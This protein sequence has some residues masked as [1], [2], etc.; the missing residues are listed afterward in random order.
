MKKY[1]LL[2][3]IALFAKF[4]YAQEITKEFSV[5][6]FNSIDAGFVF[7]IEAIKSSSEKVRIIADQ[8]IMDIIEVKVKGNTLYLSGS[9]KKLSRESQKKINNV[10]AYIYY[11]DL[12]K[13]ELSG[14][15]S[16]T[17]KDIIQRDNFQ[18]E[19][20]GAAKI[21]SLKIDVKSSILSLSGATNTTIDGN[22]GDSKI[23]VSGAAKLNISGFSNNMEI[24]C[25]GA[26]NINIKGEIKRLK[27]S[28]SGSSKVVLNGSG[29]ELSD[30]ELSGASSLNAMSFPINN[31]KISVSGV[32]KAKVNV[33]KTL[34]AEATSA[35]KIE[36]KGNP[37]I[38]RAQKSTSS[39]INKIE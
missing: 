24:S 25:S 19:S 20:S 3:I 21:N 9:T 35:S 18:I 6:S 15:S 34:D 27:Q 11:K 22:L 28:I 2:S 8:E 7:N 12:K 16:F 26:A 4:I 14:A 39:S 17:S 10:R 36:Y 13:I 29:N 33:V 5:N 23:D 37:I 32:S 30:I 31:L 38:N 1:I